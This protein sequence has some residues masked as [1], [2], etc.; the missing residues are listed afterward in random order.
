[1]AERFISQ[2]DDI[3]I[4]MELVNDSG[5]NALAE[6]QY[7]DADG[8]EFV[9]MG[10]N[11]RRFSCRAYFKNDFYDNYTAFET[12][13][14][15]PKTVHNF[16][17]PTRGLLFGHIENYQI[18]HDE[19]LNTAEV[20]F[21]FVEQLQGDFEDSLTPLITPKID[22]QFTA[23]QTAAIETF[24]D[25]MRESFGENAATLI[26][27]VID[28]S[29][30][31]VTQFFDMPRNVRA[32]VAQVDTTVATFEGFL[33]SIEQPATTL[34]SSID[35][36]T[37]IPGRVL[38]ALAQ[39][40]DR[41]IAL[42]ETVVDSP[43]MVMQS[44]YNGTLELRNAATGFER[45]VDITRAQAGALL[46]SGMFADDDQSRAQAAIIEKTS[47]WNENGEFVGRE[48]APVFMS[49][50]ELERTLSLVR[51]HLQTAFEYDRRNTN[52]T[53]MASALLRHVNIIKI[54][55]ERVVEIDVPSEISLPL[56]C[57]K[58]G[59]GYNAADRV[60]SINPQIKDP[61]NVFGMVYMYVR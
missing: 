48:T 37:G 56:L 33:S 42:T 17:H 32:F 47:A 36:G 25:S 45:E 29:Q 20:D 21:V 57:H 14:I 8:S 23:G 59:L 3:A 44:F 49:V 43:Y 61:A 39:T 50:N 41:Y 26:S 10:A 34:I 13:L 46:V 58:Y 54:D 24:N 18:R 12:A 55:R 52:L 4:D 60:M 35:Y 53:A 15:K 27:R 7:P 9:N 6:Y 51:S 28:P 31:L 19:R 22:E 5:S 16:V 1:M 11:A 30:S 2:F 40:I 38:G